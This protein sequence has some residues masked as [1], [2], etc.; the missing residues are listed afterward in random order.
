ML[1]GVGWLEMNGCAGSRS[2]TSTEGLEAIS[3]LARGHRWYQTRT[4]RLR[5][6][7]SPLRSGLH[8]GPPTTGDSGY[9]ASVMLVMSLAVVLVIEDLETPSWVW[10]VDHM[11]RSG[12]KIGQRKAV[13]K[14]GVCRK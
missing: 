7:D 8:D 14:C 6:D 2:A 4:Y 13:V 3:K 1:D 9:R 10:S 11:P 5:L 12:L